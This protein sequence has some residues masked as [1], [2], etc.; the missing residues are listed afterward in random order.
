MINPQESLIQGLRRFHCIIVKNFK[1]HKSC[2]NAQFKTENIHTVQ[3]TDEYTENIKVINLQHWEWI[4]KLTAFSR[5]CCA[6]LSSIKIITLVIITLCI[7][8]SLMMN[9]SCLNP[10]FQIKND[11]SHIK[12]NNVTD[13][14]LARIGE[15]G[16][17][18]IIDFQILNFMH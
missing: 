13:Q 3:F 5:I 10:S 8:L 7:F 6:N 11:R 15:K 2:N 14:N 1:M 18:S 17:I 12:Q 16:E 4:R 9:C